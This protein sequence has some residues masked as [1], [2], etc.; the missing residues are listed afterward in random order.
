MRDLAAQH[1]DAII[2]SP[3]LPRTGSKASHVN[4]ISAIIQSRDFL[5][6]KARSENEL[7]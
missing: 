7:H 5:T 6:A 1:Y 2:D 4:V 3:W